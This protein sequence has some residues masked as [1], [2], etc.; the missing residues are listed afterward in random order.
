MDMPKTNGLVERMNG[1]IKEA[2]TKA[3][4]YQTAQEMKKDLHG[5]FVCYNFCRKHRR[6]GGKT[7][8]EAA[9]TWYEKDPTLFIKELAVLLVYRSQSTEA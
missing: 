7:P 3:R 4:R 1:L 9:L 6:I 2:T 5:W 8:Y